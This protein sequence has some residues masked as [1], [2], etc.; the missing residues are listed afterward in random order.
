MRRT[1]IVGLAHI[2]VTTK[3]SLTG[4]LTVGGTKFSLKG[5]LDSL[6]VARFG[7]TLTSDLTLKRKAPLPSLDLS[8]QLAPVASASQVTGTI[9]VNSSALAQ[10]AADRAY[11]TAKPHPLSPLMPVPPAILGKYTVLFP[12]FSAPNH[13]L[14][15]SQ[16]PK[17]YGFARLNLTTS[18][19]ASFTGKLAD[20]TAIS[21]ANAINKD[22][23]LPIYIALYKAA[24]SLS[25]SASF[26]D[27][28]AAD[29]T[30]PGL[31]WFRPAD[32]KAKTYAN[33]WPGGIDLGLI[34]SFFNL[35]PKGTAASVL[36]GLDQNGDIGFS[37]TGGNL[38][39]DP[40]N[41]AGTVSPKNK[42]TFV[43]PPADLR[44]KLTISTSGLFSG[45]FVH[46]V[47]HKSTPVH[48]VIF[49]KQESASG[50]FIGPTESGGISFGPP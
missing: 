38:T 12:S 43:S 16:Y 31:T 3:G 13:S 22:N 11:Y 27:P 1:P 48:G 45:S 50:Y 32:A 7:K 21:Y 2:T 49:Q 5:T 6:G 23:S 33:G 35:P 29:I 15:A 24:G 30:S 46:P 20:G 41:L 19:I 28:I 4:R 37:L 8:F 47:S 14:N 9:T 17:G 10:F 25:G 18:G 36:P 44:P 40:V 26:V 42:V 39:S 34:G